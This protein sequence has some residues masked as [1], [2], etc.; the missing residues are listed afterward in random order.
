MSYCV[1]WL[2]AVPSPFLMAW[3]FT[4]GC[5]WWMF[6]QRRPGEENLRN[7]GILLMNRKLWI[8]LGLNMNPVA[9][10]LQST[11]FIQFSLLSFLLSKSAFFLLP[12]SQKRGLSPVPLRFF[13]VTWLWSPRVMV[14]AALGSNWRVHFFPLPVAPPWRSDAADD[15]RRFEVPGAR[16]GN[17]WQHMED[18]WE[19]FK[20]RISI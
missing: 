10:D 7:L 16:G 6:A 12:F 8:A 19:L 1:I 3:A 9:S 5:S 13:G 11:I 2:E 4:R 15:A 14:N 18:G 17:I 20:W